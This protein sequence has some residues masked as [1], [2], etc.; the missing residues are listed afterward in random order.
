MPSTTQEI[1]AW[2]RG[3]FYRTGAAIAGFVALLVASTPA[4]LEIVPVVFL[5]T[6][7]FALAAAYAVDWF[8]GNLG[9]DATSEAGRRSPSQSQSQSVGPGA[10]D[11]T[12]AGTE[13][14]AALQRLRERYAN[15]ELSDEAFERRIERL[16]ETAEL[17]DLV[18][19]AAKQ[20]SEGPETPAGDAPDPAAGSTIDG[21]GTDTGRAGWFD[22]L[23]NGNGSGS[24]SGSESGSGTRA[25]IGDRTAD[26]SVRS[27]EADRDRALDTN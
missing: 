5:S 4:P 25:G 10:R 18:V 27:S 22:D 2:V 20:R 8:Q 16:L 17:R 14:D 12:V 15:G 23:G 21:T 3:S 1:H 13:A 26:D 24:G 9:S 19:E 7:P 11:R 6:L